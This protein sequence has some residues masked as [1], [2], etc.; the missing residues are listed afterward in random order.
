MIEDMSLKNS[1]D[2]GSEYTEM[3]NWEQLG[4]IYAETSPVICHQLSF[5][6]TDCSMV[7]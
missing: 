1:F 3:W 6:N 2:S 5:T 4:A 7:I